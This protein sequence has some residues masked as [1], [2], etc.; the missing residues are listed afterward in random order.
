VSSE[1][2]HWHGEEQHGRQNE[3]VVSLL[4]CRCGELMTI[5]ADPKDASL[6]SRGSSRL[7]EKERERLRCRPA[8][9]G[10]VAFGFSATPTQ[11]PHRS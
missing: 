10:A 1:E 8:I 6:D 2:E 3:P 4:S 9:S 11:G 5:I 7:L